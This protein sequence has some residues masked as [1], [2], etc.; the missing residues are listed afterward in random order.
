MGFVVG[1]AEQR[2]TAP[3]MPHAGGKAGGELVAVRLQTRRRAGRLV[4]PVR[5]PL[6]AAATPAPLSKRLVSECLCLGC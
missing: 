4:G 1:A 2:S 3:S 6:P 5:S